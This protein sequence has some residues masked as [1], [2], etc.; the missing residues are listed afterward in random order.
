M[1][2]ESDAERVQLMTVHASKGLQFP[3]VFL[4]LLDAD[5]MHD[6]KL[7][8]VRDQDGGRVLDMGSVRFDAA[9]QEAMRD[10]QDEAFRKLYVALTRAEYACHVY[11]SAHNVDG[12]DPKRAA[13]SAVLERLR[14]NLQGRNIV[15]A[16][17]HID[18]SQTQTWP[19]NEGQYSPDPVQA[20]IA[21][22]ALAL[23]PA[24][25]W[26]GRY[27]F[28]TLT[29]LAGA[30]ERSAFEDS[31]ASD[32]DGGGST[33]VVADADDEASHVELAA[34]SAH[35]GENFGIAL[36]AIFEQRKLGRPMHEQYELVRRC[37]AEAGERLDGASADA[38]VARIAARVQ[39]ALDASLLPGATTA[40]RLSALAAKAMRAEMGFSYVLDGVSMQRL[41]AACAQHGEPE[42]VPP[43]APHTLRG[44]MTGA[45]DLVFEHAGRFHVLDY[46]SNYL[47]DRLSDYGPVALRVEMDRHHYRFQ[48]L[49]YTVALDRYLRQRLPGYRRRE[50]LGE[51]IYLFVRAAGLMDGAGVWSPGVW[52]H[53]FDDGLIAA[54]DAVLANAAVEAAA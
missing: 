44:L 9:Q 47:G 33:A 24:R 52:S 36:H 2:I 22:R 16:C 1:R 8:R 42:I 51:T 35:K 7:P 29:R 14:T 20:P 23:P 4:P 48:A 38:L 28:S 54:V 17:A 3:I 19:W 39:A 41:R 15:D 34:L 49:L 46:K 30:I 10:E 31:A 32:E 13:L 43:H 25:A 50:Q 11:A 40:L 21:R 27:S 26:E 45:I 53:R 18:W 12:S 37:I 5:A 6:Q